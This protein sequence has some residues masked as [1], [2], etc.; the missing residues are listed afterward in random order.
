MPLEFIHIEIRE[1]D[2]PVVSRILEELGKLHLGIHQLREGQ[3]IATEE[4]RETN[5]LL[6]QLICI[7][8]KNKPHDNVVGGS[9]TRTGDTMNPKFSGERK[10]FDYGCIFRHGRR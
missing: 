3:L 6:N 2:G 1:N 8:R 9:I 5:R 4:A 10:R 7:M